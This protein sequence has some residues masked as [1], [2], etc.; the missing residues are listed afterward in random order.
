MKILGYPN[1]S[2][3]TV[4]R[5]TDPFKHL[6]Q[7]GI[8]AFVVDHGIIEEEIAQADIVVIKGL[9][10]KTGIAL[11]YAYQ[12]EKG[13]KIVVDMDDN[14]RLDPSNPFQKDHEV[15][16]AYE[17]FKITL[18]IADMVTTTSEHLAEKLSEYN[19]NIVILENYIDLDRWDLQP[20]LKNTANTIRIGWCGSMTHIKDLEFIEEPLTAICRDYPNVELVLV[21]DM[22]L[23]NMFKGCKKEVQLGVPM[24]V[25]PTKLS[26]MRL[27]IGIAPLLHNEF[28]KCK[29]RIKHYEYAINMIPGVY[30][31]TVYDEQHFDGYYGLVAPDKNRWYA[32]LRNLIQSKELREDIA[33]AAYGFVKAHK[34]LHKHSNQWVDAYQSLLT[35]G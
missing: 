31:P 1:P 19:K 16:D 5:F 33:N 15:T 3:A 20:K 13:L 12:Q 23:N 32:C 17:M 8:D 21:G 28:N 30:S 11:L 34:S 27:D 25:W 22:R 7:K 14:P 4:W 26:G 18:N 24:D 10:D 6:R 2:A 9:V 35:Q 29:S